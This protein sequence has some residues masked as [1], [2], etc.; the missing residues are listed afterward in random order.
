MGE[1]PADLGIAVRGDGADLSDLI[2]GGDLLGARLE[3]GDGGFDGLI[4]AALEIHRVHAG[5]D[6]FGSLADDRLGKHGRSRRAVTGDGAR[7]GGDLAH[8]LGAHVLELVG[9]FDLLGDGHTILGDARRAVGFLQHHVAAL[10]TQCDPYRIGEDVHP[11]QQSVARIGRKSDVFGS[12]GLNSSLAW[13]W[14]MPIWRPSSSK[15]SSRSH[16]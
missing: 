9:K 1:H 15:W 8:H 5:G 12:H 14:E 10:R 16:P 4:D 2:I 11:A 13:D 3:V 7:P 6:R